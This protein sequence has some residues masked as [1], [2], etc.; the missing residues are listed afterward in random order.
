MQLIGASGAVS[1]G[2]I[3]EACGIFDDF[4]ALRDIYGRISR[5]EPPDWRPAKPKVFRAQFAARAQA[6]LLV[7]GEFPSITRAETVF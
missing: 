7:D 6:E 1:R 4:S 5:L 3:W 2:A